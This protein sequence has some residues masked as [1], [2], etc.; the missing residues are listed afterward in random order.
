ML[1]IIYFHSIIILSQQIIT[2]TATT[3]VLYQA[4]RVCEGESGKQGR[5]DVLYT[6]A[7]NSIILRMSIAD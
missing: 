1:T 6:S 3:Y 5:Q 2:T 7:C 4:P